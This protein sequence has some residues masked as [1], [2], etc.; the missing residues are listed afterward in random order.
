[1]TSSRRR[2][3]ALPLVA[4][5]AALVLALAPGTRAATATLKIATV[6]PEGS[7][8]MQ[9]FDKMKKEV[10]EATGG[11]VEFKAYPGGVLGEEKDVLFKMKVGQVD[12][13][14]FMGTGLG[15][16][17]PDT[18]AVMLPF[19]FEDLEEVDA[20]FEK[21]T[22]QLDDRCR[23]NGY[24]ALGWI[25]IGFSYLYSTQPIASLAQLR[26]AK[27]WSAPGDEVF[28]A[29][30]QAARVSAI[31][32]QLSDVLT[33]LQTGL[34]DTVY[35]PP[36]AAIAL[37][38]FTRVKYRNDLELLYSFGGLFV[39]ERAWNRV[40]EE[41]R[42]KV[43][44]ICR[45]RSRELTAEVRRSNVEALQ[46]LAKNGIQDVHADEAAVREFAE[47]SR[48]ANE[49]MKGTLFPAATYERVQQHL[50]E[51]RAGRH[52]P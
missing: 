18:R 47:V 39:A 36:L 29:L 44:E 22:P 41:H 13:A 40:P 48:Q 25:E 51:H 11:A 45:R 7:A 16:V 21:I 14:G 34:I 35:A 43:S 24:V 32:V 33:A 49:R 26:A 28:D 8:W 46:V 37:Q 5:A 23:E 2:V 19:V 15:K 6:A 30:F 31:P 42:A 50:R 17:C 3:T 38:W 4:L 9:M 52:A 20:V 12:G 10:L 1:M 27:P